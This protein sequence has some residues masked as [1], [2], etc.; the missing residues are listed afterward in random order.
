MFYDTEKRQY[1]KQGVIVDEAFNPNM[2]N[3]LLG[4]AMRAKKRGVQ[5]IRTHVKN[6]SS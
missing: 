1:R 4:A 2:L 3:S 5:I 6:P